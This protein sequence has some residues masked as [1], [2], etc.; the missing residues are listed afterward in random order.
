[1]LFFKKGAWVQSGELEGKGTQYFK[2]RKFYLIGIIVCFGTAVFARVMMWPL[3]RM[4]ALISNLISFGIS[5]VSLVWFP[6][7]NSKLIADLPSLASG[8]SGAGL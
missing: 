3:N 7:F 2:L 5:F 1:M 6:F 4:S 8:G